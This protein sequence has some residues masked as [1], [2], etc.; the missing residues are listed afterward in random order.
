MIIDKDFQEGVRTWLLECFGEEI[1]FNISERN[2]RFLEESLELV[3]SLGCTKSDALTLVDYVYGRPLGEPFQEVGGVMV[4]LAALCVASNLN[5]EECAETEL[6]RIWTKIEKIREKQATK[7]KLS[8]LPMH[9]E[10][11][12]L[13]AWNELYPQLYDFVLEGGYKNAFFNSLKKH[14]FRLSKTK[15]EV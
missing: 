4:T 5:L 14:G 15:A 9:V 1:S 11:T 13:E 6:A 2:H 8:P 3:Q 10:E 7:P 12:D